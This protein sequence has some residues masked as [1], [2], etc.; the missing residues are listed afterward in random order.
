MDRL[1]FYYVNAKYVSFLRD[2]YDPRVPK[3][4]L[5]HYKHEKFF[6]GV[7]FKINNLDYFA[8]V[9]SYQDINPVTFNIR[10]QGNRVISSIRLN[11]MFPVVDGVYKSLPIETFTTTYKLIC[12]NELRYCNKHRA[13]ILELAK[14][15]YNKMSSNDFVDE[16][17]KRLYMKMC[18]NFKKLERGARAFINSGKK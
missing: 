6:V 7:V 17:E 18:C 9:S 5:P 11:Y 2:K 3:T 16:A 8:P 12:Y 10:G 13:E 14:N 1:Q 4:I 15:I